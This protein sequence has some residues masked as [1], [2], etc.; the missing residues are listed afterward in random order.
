MPAKQIIE[1]PVVTFEEPDQII[2]QATGG[3]PGST[4]R[5]SLAHA[6]RQ[7]TIQRPIE[8]ELRAGPLGPSNISLD[9]ID[10][11]ELAEGSDK[12]VRFHFQIPDFYIHSTP[13]ARITFN[14][15]NN[16]TQTTAGNMRLRLE[17]RQSTPGDLS[18]E[19]PA[20]AD[21]NFP[22]PAITDRRVTR[23]DATWSLLGLPDI[24]NEGSAGA[25][26]LISGGLTRLS[27]SD[28]TNDTHN[29]SVMVATHAMFQ[30]L[31]KGQL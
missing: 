6:A 27:G 12:D 18:N 17:I 25:R 15:I 2:R 21:F 22:V 13:V 11:F 19:L 16:G 7:V 14:F 8:F 28:P 9:D 1:L 23:L 20:V 31:F 26:P 24:P 29:G 5:N 10:G 3:G 4:G 30:G